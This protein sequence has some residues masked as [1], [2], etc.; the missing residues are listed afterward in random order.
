MTHSFS[1][2]SSYSARSISSAMSL[3]GGMQLVGGGQ[4]RI[5]S[6][7]IQTRSPSVYGGA[8]GFGTRISQSV[9]TS[10]SLGSFSDASVVNNEKLTMQNLND[11]LASYLEKVR[12]LEA[13]N[14]KLELQIREFYEKRAP[15][16][17]SDF[18]AYFATISD[19]RAQFMKKFSEN[20]RIIL[21][22][23]NAQLAA[24]D[25][26]MKYDT[27]QNARVMVEA[28]VTRL[29][30]VRDS[31]TLAIG[32][33]EMQVEGLK[34]EL[35]YIK[36][37]HEEEMR[38]LRVQQSGTVNVEV[39]STASTDLMKVLVEMREQYEAL[40]LKNNQ[41]LEKWFK[42][43]MD[44]LQTEITVRTKDVKSFHTQ[45]SE[46]KRTYQSL[47]IN[48]Q[49]VHTEIQCLQQNLEE[50]KSRYSLQLSQVQ[51]SI[52]ALETE[53]QQLR[54]SIE[55]Q[56]S[57]YNLL[58]DIKMR[59]ELE[60]AEYRRLLE[61]GLVEQQT[62]SVVISK[63]V[64]VE[65]HKPHIER[66]VKTIVEEI[67]DG[68][69]VSS[70]VDTQVEDIHITFVD[71]MT[72]FTGVSYSGRSV[73]GGGG[74]RTSIS[75]GGYGGGGMVQRSYARSVHGGAGGSGARISV[76]G[77]GG[78]AGF[79]YGSGGG[80]GAG[81]GFG[82]GG[83][84]YGGGSSYSFSVG[85]GGGF[86][87]GDSV[88]ISANEKATM[89]NLNDR[90]ASY[91]EKVRSLE[92]ANAE[93][94]LKIRQFLESKTSPKARDYSA[95]EATIADLQGKIQDATRING[96][97]YLAIDNAKLAADDFRTKYENELAM[98]QSVE[99]DI[100]GLK[101]LLDELTLARSDLEMQIEGLKEELIFLKKNHEEELAAMRNQMSGQINVEVDAKQQPDLSVI[102]A[103]IREQ[104]ESVAAK[105]Q[106]ELQNWFQTKSEELSK[107]VAVHTET[108]QT[109]KS[110]ISEIRR[111]LQGLEIELQSQL[112]MKASLENTLAETEMRYS[113][114]LQG[115]QM[116]VTSLEEQL[117]QLRADME[118]QSQEYNMLLDIKT[119]LEMEIAQYKKLLDG[120]GSFTSG[121]GSSSKTT[122]SKV[123]VVT[124]ELKDGKVVSSSTTTTKS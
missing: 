63:V 121:H 76:A 124:E 91:L 4:S 64:E 79:G 94:E 58:L 101:R 24:D 8:G 97:I 103:E 116:Q 115:L 3:S 100:A 49:S 67:V 88:N 48:R 21:Q 30:G 17:S 14:R 43:K 85:G 119:R 92:K 118:R 102:M 50:V 113:M 7:V 5:S 71:C 106:R 32:D 25:F 93:L 35:V 20:Q 29:R 42:L 15:S 107:E 13:A 45:L 75:G 83:G 86:G 95:Y 1:R 16:V 56:Q 96:G 87:A 98:R 74:L 90:L 65:E 81:F 66:R 108:L 40:V 12:S 31:L 51:I 70:S 60:I 114:Q 53:L 109:S 59:L 122:T 46:L 111:T 73:A 36:S 38:Q 33:L 105:N 41:E 9:F 22:I 120:E 52:T 23:D 82:S 18:T 6:G 2:Q 99:A 62:K 110:E 39:D 26:K 80:A 89:Q 61:G 84:G 117:V 54:V 55:Q 44:G 68:K 10:D 34:D 78:G 112:S 77:G 37:N 72:Y 57:E 47:E 11:R 19:L 104:Y 27:E 28:D 69:V 123:I